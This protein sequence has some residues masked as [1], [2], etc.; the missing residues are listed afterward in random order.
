VKHKNIKSSCG[1]SCDNDY[2]HTVLAVVM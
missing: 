1:V 2:A